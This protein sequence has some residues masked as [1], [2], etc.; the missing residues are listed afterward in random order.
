MDKPREDGLETDLDL[1]PDLYNEVSLGGREEK[2]HQSIIA[3]KITD[4]T[5]DDNP[6]GRKRVADERDFE[7]I[8]KAI[9]QLSAEFKGLRDEVKDLKLK[10]NEERRRTTMEL[11]ARLRLTVQVHVLCKIRGPAPGPHDHGFA[12]KAAAL[13]TSNVT[14][15]R[16]NR[17][18]RS[19]DLCMNRGL[20]AVWT[21][22]MKF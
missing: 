5:N 18:Q 9:S 8:G 22:R 2:Q 19:A 4:E 15:F 17:G 14:Q 3:H 16:G 6:L 10:Y 20:R 7:T 12:G 1:D 11:S 13:H 21:T